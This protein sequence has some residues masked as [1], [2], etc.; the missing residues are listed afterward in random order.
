MMRQTSLAFCCLLLSGAIDYSRAFQISRL[1]QQSATLNVRLFLDRNDNSSSDKKNSARSNTDK[2]NREDATSKLQVEG[3]REEPAAQ[4]VEAEAN[5]KP[6]A[7]SNAKPSAKANANAEAEPEAEEEEKSGNEELL[8]QEVNN[9]LDNVWIGYERFTPMVQDEL[10]NNIR[11][12]LMKLVLDATF[13]SDTVKSQGE[14]SGLLMA[15]GVTEDEEKK[16][17][18]IQ[19]F[20]KALSKQTNSPTVIEA[21]PKLTDSFNADFVDPYGEVN[22]LQKYL[23]ECSKKCDETTIWYSPYTSICQSSGWGKSRLLR[24]FSK[25][26]KVLYVSFMKKSGGGY[27][28]ET[29]KA[30]QYLNVGNS[31]IFF[32]RLKFA[33]K[34]RAELDY[35]IDFIDHGNDFWKEVESSDVSVKELKKK[36]GEVNVKSND[37][38]KKNPSELESKLIESNIT[39]GNGNSD[40]VFLVF[41]EARYLLD[42]SCASRIGGEDSNAFLELRRHLKELRKPNNMGEIKVFGVFADTSSK[43]AN[44]S[45][46]KSSAPSSREVGGERLFRPFL[47]TGFLDVMMTR[48]EQLGNGKEIDWHEPQYIEKLGRPLWTSTDEP[49][50]KLAY[51]KLTFRQDESPELVALAVFLSRTGL[52]LSQAHPSTGELV[53]NH[54]ATLLAVDDS[55]EKLLVTY[56]SDPVLSEGARI[57]WS[58]EHYA[59]KTMLPAVRRSLMYGQVLEGSLGESVAVTVMLMAMD[60]A[61]KLISENGRN[62]TP[63][64][65]AHWV[66]VLDFFCCLTVC[67]K[68]LKLGSKADDKLKVMKESID[69]GFSC[70]LDDSMLICV[71][72]FIQWYREIKYEDLKELCKRRAG[73]ILQ[74]NHN[75]I[76]LLL[77]FWK[78]EEGKGGCEKFGVIVVQVKNTEKHSDMRKIGYKLDEKYIFG[79]D[80]SMQNIPIIRVVLELGLGR[81]TKTGQEPPPPKPEVVEMEIKKS[82]EFVTVN[83]STARSAKLIQTPQEMK[84]GEFSFLRFKGIDS[85]PFIHEEPA[86]AEG[87]KDLLIGPLQPT[88]WWSMVSKQAGAAEKIKRNPTQKLHL[89][90]LCVGEEKEGDL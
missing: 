68:D 31:Q 55:R 44:F 56:I 5:A 53:A 7:K 45:P 54:M 51:S 41:D 19:K 10:K 20:L 35:Y 37:E 29:T 60:H 4:R 88:K 34:K 72:H 63:W 48:A 46:P 12:K 14:L 26:N 59:V 62:S 6:S 74:R 61:Q 78:Q 17:N 16:T 65:A 11:D 82:E 89:S 3:E 71:T 15:T 33:V 22:S 8:E 49:P 23:T 75:G 21:D 90:K 43:L 1:S 81:A 24:Q 18:A 9:L 69:G 47:L 67:T 2:A 66:S 80:E 83:A 32:N 42:I 70:S 84:G 79:Q 58:Q 57:V 39:K 28:P 52:F 25:S 77:P 38:L 85:L 13:L 27:P 30:I 87:L 64:N 76:D 86:L 50:I 36:E 40:I 73:C